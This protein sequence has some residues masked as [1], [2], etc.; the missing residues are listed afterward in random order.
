VIRLDPG[1]FLIEPPLRLDPEKE[2][3]FAE[4]WR[5]L[6]AGGAYDLGDPKHEFL[7]WLVAHEDVLLHGSNRVA[8]ERLEP[9]DQLDAIDRPVRGVFASPDGIWPLFFAIADRSRTRLLFNGCERRNGRGV[10]FFAV[11]TDE[12]PW[13]RG[14]VFVLPRAG[15]RRTHGFE[16]LSEE[17]VEPLARID[18]EPADF[19]FVDRVFRVRPGS[20]LWRLRARLF[21]EVVRTQSRRLA[22]R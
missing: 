12:D 21:L 11:G 19:P 10:Y 6:R 16:W 15:F 4:Q 14:T 22:R 17:P 3:R 20:P 2:A 18:V 5:R 13:T 1:H 9:R 8:G 7:R